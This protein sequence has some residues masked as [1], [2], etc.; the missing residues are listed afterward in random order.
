MSS[1][2]I[3]PGAAFTLRMIVAVIFAIAIVH[4]LRS[5]ASFIATLDNYQVLPAGLATPAAWLVLAAE[6]SVAAGL[7]LGSQNAAIG[8]AALLVLYTGAI[9]INLLR[10]RRDIDCGCSGPAMRQTLSPWLLWRNVVLTALACAAGLP[11]AERPLT[12]LDAF[13]AVAATA[14]F[15]LLYSAANQLAATNTRYVG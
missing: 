14:A 6:V 12:L 2:S 11:I 8:A 3:D 7:L 9:G 15:L 4:K 5:P 13:T 1:I 10:D